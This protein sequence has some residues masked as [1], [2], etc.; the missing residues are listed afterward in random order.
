MPIDQSVQSRNRSGPQPNPFGP[1]QKLKFLAQGAKVPA[2]SRA[3]LAVLI[4]LADMAN[5]NT[6][7]AWPSFAT[8]AERAGVSGRHAKTAIKNLIA[9]GFIEV[10]EQGNR[11]KSNRYK[12]NLRAG[13]SDLGN[14]TQPSDLQST[15][16]VNSSVRGSDVECPDVVIP[17]SPES[18]HPSEHKAS[19][20][21]DRSQ[22]DGGA[23]NASPSRARQPDPRKDQFPEF[24]EAIGHRATVSESEQ[25]IR[26]FLCE[27]TEYDEIVDG[28]RRWAAYNTATGGRRKA[29]PVQWLLKEKWRDDWTVPQS[30]RESTKAPDPRPDPVANADIPSKDELHD[31]IITGQDVSA[32]QTSE[33]NV[34]TSRHSLFHRAWLRAFGKQNDHFDKCPECHDVLDFLGDEDVDVGCEVWHQLHRDAD[35]AKEADSEWLLAN[36]APKRWRT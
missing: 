26:E 7:I 33:Y 16:V 23:P 3:E 9:R 10:T 28:G 36:P 5:S 19:E 14:T 31:M 20:G 4:V 15:R 8:L 1:V 32:Y 22:A 29:S 30:R 34:W 17:S 12:I 24:W 11:I 25:A 35:A 13:G 6:G 21:W 27:G 2:M 18:I